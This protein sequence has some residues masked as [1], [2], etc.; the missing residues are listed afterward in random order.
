MGFE[1]WW[2]ENKGTFS[3]ADKL[4]AICKK[5]WK[6]GQDSIAK[7]LMELQSDKGKLLDRIKLLGEVLD[8]IPYDND[9]SRKQKAINEL[10]E[11]EF[12]KMVSDIDREILIADS[13]NNDSMA[14]VLRACSFSLRNN[15]KK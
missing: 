1:D 11:D 6:A 7:R 2:N 13:L 9:E 12:N 3:D 8:S 10:S 15:R 4:K 5:A 14:N